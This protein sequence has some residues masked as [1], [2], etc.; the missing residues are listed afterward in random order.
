[1]PVPGDP[2]GGLLRILPQ[3]RSPDRSPCFGVNPLRPASRLAA[4]TC[5]VL[6]SLLSAG[7]PARAEQSR[8]ADRNTF[9]SLVEGRSLTR[10]GITLTVMPDG[11][12]A[13]RAFGKP[14]TGEWTWRDGYFCRDLFHDGESLGPNCQV[15]EKRGDALRFIADRGAGARADLRLR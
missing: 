10:L 13:G 1:M 8:I 14:V 3:T 4:A 15:V 11:T 9:V 5:V 2:V 12:I 6:V 7:T